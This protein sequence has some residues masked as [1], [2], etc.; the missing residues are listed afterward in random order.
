MSSAPRVHQ[1]LRA[2]P[3]LEVADMARSLAFY[4]S[5]LGFDVD[6]WGE[7]ASFAIAQRGTATLGLVPAK[8]AP[9]IS[10]HHWSAYI[11]VTDVD[12]LH[13]ELAAN[14]VVLPDGPITHTEYACRDFTMDDPD[15]HRIAFGQVLKPD[16]LGPGLSCRTGRDTL[17]GPHQT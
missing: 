11:Y 13:A 3:V 4:T 15:G 5:K 8:G 17:N 6:T 12:A 14:G 7:P 16:P 10:A 2:M 9:A 1:L